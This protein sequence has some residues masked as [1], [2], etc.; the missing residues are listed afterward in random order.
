MW[1]VIES[2]VPIARCGTSVTYYRPTRYNE[3]PGRGNAPAAL[4][5]RRRQG[6][7]SSGPGRTRTFCPGL[8]PGLYPGVDE[9]YPV[10]DISRSP[11][12]TR[13]PSRWRTARTDTIVGPA[14]NLFPD[15]A[16]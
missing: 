5:V 7:R 6:R 11:R 1:A 9:A 16:Q 12:I 8:S 3:R 15:V 13:C 14:G 10:A 2:S 4:R